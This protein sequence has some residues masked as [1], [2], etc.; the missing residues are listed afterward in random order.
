M[1]RRLQMLLL[2][3]AALAALHWFDARPA[4]EIDGV[5]APAVPKR[6]APRQEIAAT[7]PAG[8]AT[9]PVL[10]P[11]P[12]LAEP[13]GDPFALPAPP[14]SAPV[15]PSPP[16]AVAPVAAAPPPPSP[17]APPSFG[18]TAIGRWEQDDKASIFFQH[19]RATL[20]AGVGDEL[21]GGFTLTRIDGTSY[22]VTHMPTGEVLTRP[23]GTA[24]PT[25]GAFA[26]GR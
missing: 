24:S 13:A 16:P 22:Q 7:Q 23:I 18:L 11:K 19:G 2:V 1:S 15:P 10:L 4:P 26:Q 9:G 5:V 25:G 6:T 12:L 20:A 14:V 21:P 17:P 3:L 8:P